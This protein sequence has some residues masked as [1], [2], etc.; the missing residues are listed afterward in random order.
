[1]QPEV[2]TGRVSGLPFFYSLLAHTIEKDRGLENT[3]LR[4]SLRGGLR[5]VLFTM[6]ITIIVPAARRCGDR[7]QAALR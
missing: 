1:M 3:C 2:S 4:A 6:K 5:A 7:K